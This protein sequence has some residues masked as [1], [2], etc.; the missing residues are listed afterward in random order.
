L[1]DDRTLDHIASNGTFT[2]VVFDVVYWAEREG[3]VETLVREA[4]AFVPGN[5]E[6]QD[7]ATE[8]EKVRRCP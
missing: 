6:L 2:D 8:F 7:F 3:R 4:A 1:A 5:A